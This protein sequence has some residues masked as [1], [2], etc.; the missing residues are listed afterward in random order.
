MTKPM[1]IFVAGPYTNASA[2][3]RASN[4]NKVHEVLKEIIKKGHYILECHSLEHAF[5]SDNEL[6][7]AHFLRQT[8]N[9]LERCDA[10][11]IL[12]NSPGAD[13]ELDKAKGLG[14]PVYSRLE[15]I[16]KIDDSIELTTVRGLLKNQTKRN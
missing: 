2:P 7:H 6:T 14:L 11:F 3:K 9:W 5:Y 10:L 4:V 8:L 13:M 1:L 12:D 15:D 16:P